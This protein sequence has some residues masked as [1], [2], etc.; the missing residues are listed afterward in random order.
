[1][2]SSSSSLKLERALIVLTSIVGFAQNVGSTIEYDHRQWKVIKQVTAS[3]GTTVGAFDV[4]LLESLSQTGE[5]GTG[6][7]MYDVQLLIREADKVDYEFTNSANERLP[8][9]TAGFY[10]DDGLEIKDVTNDGIPETLFHS[11]FL[12]VSDF[13]I[14]EHVL[15]Y[16]R[17]HRSFTDVA[18][19]SFYNSGTHGLRWLDIGRRTFAVT[20]DR[21]WSPTVAVEDRCHYCASPFQYDI[22]QWSEKAASFV[23]LRRLFGQK[24]YDDAT[25]ALGGDWVLIQAGLKH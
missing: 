9:E 4:E 12:A 1:M 2:R 5:S 16:D 19:T 10:M 17:A 18:P 20:A 3:F 13:E 22:Y 23:K 21:N 11:G 6:D 15:R 25:A 14:V 8:D 7:P 24:S